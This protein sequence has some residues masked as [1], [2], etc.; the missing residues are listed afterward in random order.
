M[1]LAPEIWW[2][3][4]WGDAEL[5]AWWARTVASAAREAPPEARSEWTR[6]DQA[7][8]RVR[9]PVPARGM[10]EHRILHRDFFLFCNRAL[11]GVAQGQR[12]AV[13]LEA[14]GRPH[15]C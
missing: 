6:W 11:R 5:D 9:P 3:P 13:L 15:P 7:P 4:R 10:W 12:R 2:P 14:Q 1:S 8:G